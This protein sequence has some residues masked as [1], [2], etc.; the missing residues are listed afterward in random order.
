MAMST[1]AAFSVVA[2]ILT[3]FMR[4]VLVRAN[5]RLESGQSTVAK[6]MK[7]Q[8]QTAIGGL[9]DEE[10]VAYQEEFRYVA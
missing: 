2:I 6:E 3:L 10:R 7:G 8:S 1:N 9:T 5:K 4:H